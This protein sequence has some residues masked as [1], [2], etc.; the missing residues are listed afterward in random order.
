MHPEGY[1]AVVCAA[2]GCGWG[3]DATVA[4]PLVDAIRRAVAASDHGVMVTTGCLFG[5]DC[6]VRPAA[7]VLL[8]QA[9]DAERRPTARAIAIGPLRTSVDVEAV[10]VWLRAGRLDP[11]L[12]PAHLLV[13]YLRSDVRGA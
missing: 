7:P 11:L 9:C 10:G 3:D 6:G 13:P 8:V 1:T 12:L 2:R 4:G 5:A